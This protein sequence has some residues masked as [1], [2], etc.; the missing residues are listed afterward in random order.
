VLLAA[1]PLV[2]A[3]GR[4]RW[5]P[6]ALAAL[7]ALPVFAM[8]L[9]AGFWWIEGL[10]ATRIEYLES[11]A[12][13]RPFGYFV[14]ANLASFALILGPA[15][16]AGAAALRE[17]TTWLLVGG[18]LAAVALADASGMSKAEV[19]RIWLP[20]AAWVLLATSALPAASR[21]AWLAATVAF[22]LVLEVAVWQPW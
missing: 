6:I 1:I 5:R 11:V 22:G 18:A 3:A 2:V 21:R 13:L 17:R 20:F 12:R 7:G 14:V 10:L 16:I 4:R 9:A 19:E 8:F 15:T